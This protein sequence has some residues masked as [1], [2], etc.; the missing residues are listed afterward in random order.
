MQELPERYL[1]QFIRK[2]LQEKMVF[3]GGPRQVGK[4]TIALKIL[5][6]RLS[7]AHTKMP[8]ASLKSHP[9]YM[10]WDTIAGRKRIRSGQLT[11]ECKLIVL[12]EIHKFK[13]WRN[14]VKGFYDEHWPEKEFL[15]TGSA[16]LDYFNRGGESLHGRYHYLR[17]HPFNVTELKISS[18]ES[19]APLFEF[20]GFPEPLIKRDKTHWRRWQNERV[21][22]II[23]EDLRD[24]ER[25]KDLGDLE[26]LIDAIPSRVGSPLSV[27]SLREDLSVSHQTIERYLKIFENLYVCF[28]IQPFGSPKIKA[29]KKEQK[30][31]MWDWSVIDDIG[32]RFEN[33]VASALL[34][35]CHFIQDT[36][37]HKMEL[38][39]LRDQ[40]GREVDFV[41]LKDKKPLFAVEAKYGETKQSPHLK[42]FQERTSI[43]EFYQVH[44]NDDDFG[45]ADKNGR[46]MPI[47]KF[48]Q[49]KGLV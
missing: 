24:L 23:Q 34:K 35:S 4:T 46:I 26:I 39:Y 31:Y 37:G 13:L 42:Y 32:A 11:N 28:R 17:M 14:L 1:T 25:V 44:A 15:I 9:A 18:K 48:C 20:G 38:R 10:N 27:N 12:D 8:A 36:Q 49:F 7:Q 30:L 29:V 5:A 6:N 3:L 40:E 45:V 47:W 2:D 21:T 41:V 22:R 16:R 43:P 33:L 19:F